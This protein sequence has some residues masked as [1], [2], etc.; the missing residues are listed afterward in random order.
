MHLRRAV[1][2]VG[3]H[4]LPGNCPRI[5]LAVAMMCMSTAL[6]FF[7][8]IVLMQLISKDN[9]QEPSHGFEVFDLTAQ[10][11]IALFVSGLVLSRLVQS[12]RRVVTNPIVSNTAFSLVHDINRHFLSLSH[13]YFAGTPIGTMSECFTTGSTGAQEFTTQLFNQVAPATI[14]SAV[15]IG[16][17]FTRFGWQAGT[18]FLAMFALYMA[19]NLAMSNKIAAA[20]KELVKSRGEMTRGITATLTGFENIQLFN[21]TEYELEKVGKKLTIMKQA[22]TRALSLPDQIAFGQWL[23]TGGGFV[24]ILMLTYSHA[25]QAQLVGLCFYMLLYINLFNGFGDGLSKIGSSCINLSQVGEIFN[26]RSNVP[27][28]GD[29]P[30]VPADGYEIAFENVQFYYGDAVSNAALKKVSFTVRPGEKLGIVGQSGAGK[31]TLTKLLY[32]FYDVKSGVIKINGQDIRTISLAALRELIAVVNQSPTVFND[33][34]ENNIWYGAISRFGNTVDA[35]RLNNALRVSELNQYVTTLPNGLK[36]NVGER[37]LKISGGQLQRLALARA[38]IK[39][40]PIILF[41]EATSALDSKT[42]QAIQSSLD[43]AAHG[44]TTITISH[45]LYNVKNADRILVLDDGK[46]IEEGTHSELLDKKG[47]YY[48]IWIKQSKEY[49]NSENDA[50]QVQVANRRSPS[51]FFAPPGT[52]NGDMDERTPLLSSSLNA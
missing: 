5:S 8:A 2:T 16:I 50:A 13:Q 44:R 14:E 39:E 49:E 32:R 43:S 10:S 25:S 26:E 3:P 15:A 1:A 4:L 9:E 23:I 12:G 18:T 27:D 51:A 19:Y 45:K 24:S 52:I 36:T 6:N 34:F 40:A 38:V 33:T 46:I 11:L 31:S 22:N 20:Q 17:S 37:G 48:G 29:V 21:N 28:D 42:E 35:A 41:D 30:L 47:V 7:S